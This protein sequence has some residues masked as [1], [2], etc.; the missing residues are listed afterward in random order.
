VKSSWRAVVGDSNASS[1][2]RDFNLSHDHQLQDLTVRVEG[3]SGQY[4]EHQ[5]R[6][7]ELLGE[8]SNSG[9]SILAWSMSHDA[10]LR[11]VPSMYSQMLTSSSKLLRLYLHEVHWAL[12][13]LR[14]T[15][16]SRQALAMGYLSRH[17]RILS[18]LQMVMSK[19][20]PTTGTLSMIYPKSRMRQA[21]TTKNDVN[22]GV[23]STCSEISRR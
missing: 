9:S 5:D 18:M 16:S 7:P 2:L 3:L 8:I 23:Y 19:R 10:R 22:S 13:S 6:Q 20:T 12:P 11:D 21:S 15:L 17:R 4:V 1:L 14:K